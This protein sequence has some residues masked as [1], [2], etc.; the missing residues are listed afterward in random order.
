MIMA[1]IDGEVNIKGKCS[2][3]VLT[4]SGMITYNTQ[5]NTYDTEVH[6]SFKPSPL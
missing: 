2:Q 4:L 3:D 1:L 5:N 6:S